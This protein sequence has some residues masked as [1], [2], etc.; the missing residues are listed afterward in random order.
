MLT[1]VIELTEKCNLGCTFCL[2][3]SFKNSGM[4]LKILEK[5]IKFLLEYEKERIDFVWHGGEP[6]I[7]GSHFFENIILFQKKYNVN[8][9]K[10]LNA[11]QT[12]ATLFSEEFKKIFKINNFVIGTSIQGPK[13]VHDCTR[14]DLFG[15]GTY[16]RVISKIKKMGEKPSAI[17]VLT[18][19]ILG[20][21]EET[22]KI[23]KKYSRGA[24]ISE[25]FPGGQIPNKKERL[26]NNQM[27]S[28]KEYGQ[29]M[30][31][32]YN[33]WKKDKNP[34]DL[35]PITEIIQSFIRKKSKGCIYSQQSCN[36]IVIG[37]KWNGDFY[38]CLRAAE[39]KE[40]FLG[41][42]LKTNPLKQFLAFGKRDDQNRMKFLKKE[43]CL[44]CEF[45]NQCNGGCPQE[46]LVLWGDYAHK[47]Y[48]CEGRKMLFQ[49]IKKDIEKLKNEI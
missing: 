45:F 44:K 2:R 10:I 24:R 13:K 49:E 20:K 18:K 40:F 33:I 12:N 19:E 43:G 21:E 32:F 34:I 30:V 39:K 29:S 6:L 31:N 38:T 48:Y 28:S 42:I 23:L 26:L 46:S 25:Y 22:Y 4:S 8:N 17:T 16:E 47:T 15:K 35:R 36:F 41:N 14:I 11:V 3:P 1:A 5:T 7:L 37:I 9:V 27:P